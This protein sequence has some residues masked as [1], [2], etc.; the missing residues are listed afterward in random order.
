MKE[1]VSDIVK[2]IS[3]NLLVDDNDATPA[4]QAGENKAKE[5][6]SYATIKAYWFSDF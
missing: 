6:E 2:K 4:A 3:K 1:E 5:D